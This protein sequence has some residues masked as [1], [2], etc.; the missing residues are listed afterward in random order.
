[1]NHEFKEE[2]TAK[3]ILKIQTLHSLIHKKRRL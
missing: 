2:V 1:M 3:S